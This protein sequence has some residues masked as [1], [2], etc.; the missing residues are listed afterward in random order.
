MRIQKYLRPHVAYTNRIRPSTR[1]RF[2]S[3]HLKGLVKS[4]AEKDWFWYCDIRTRGKT[5]LTG[6][7]IEGPDIKCFVIFL[8]LHFNSNKRISWANQNSRLG[9]Y[10]NTNLKYFPYIIYIF[11][12]TN[13]CFSSRITLKIVF[14]LRLRGCVVVFIHEKENWQCFSRLRSRHFPP[15]LDHVL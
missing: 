1:I 13:W 10:K 8:D 4:R 11:S 12:C 3:G 7:P 2:V 15:C 5:K 9:T 14:S 6:F